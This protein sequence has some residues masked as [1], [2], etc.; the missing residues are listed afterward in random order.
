MKQTIT[1]VAAGAGHRFT[2]SDHQWPLQNYGQDNPAECS[3]CGYS[4]IH[5]NRSRDSVS[6]F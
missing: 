2:S 6:R 5:R 3:I 4:R 1:Q